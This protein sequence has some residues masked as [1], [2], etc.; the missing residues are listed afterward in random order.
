MKQIRLLA[1]LAILCMILPLASYAQHQR[2]SKRAEIIVNNDT[3]AQITFFI[4]TERYGRLEWTY[5]PG[6]DSYTSHGPNGIRL[7]VRGNDVIEIA[8]WGRFYI[9]DVSEFR[10]GVWKLSLRHARR[11]ARQR[12]SR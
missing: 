8:D 6:N 9:Q 4:T 7:M 10:D 2:H 12:S 11:V 3:S 1:I 5:A